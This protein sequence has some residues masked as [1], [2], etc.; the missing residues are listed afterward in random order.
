MAPITGIVLCGGRGRR[1]GGDKA[2]LQVD[3]HP[4]WRVVADRSATVCDPVLLARGSMPEL[5][6]N[7]YRVI[8]DADEDSGPLGG[9]VAGLRSSPHRLAA[10]LAVDLPYMSPSMIRFLASMIDTHDAC[11]PLPAGGPE[12]LHAVYS[13]GSL[14]ILEVALVEGRLRLLDALTE[15]DTVYLGPDDWPAEVDLRFAENLN[16]PQDV[17]SMRG[18]TIP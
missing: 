18:R 7:D 15:L 6:Q 12:P 3:G 10:V 13:L 5:D 4:L 1:M 11:V 2:L 8:E 17:E 16:R 14:R 9:I